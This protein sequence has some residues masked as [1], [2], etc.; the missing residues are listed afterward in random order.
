MLS[1][2]AGRA[3]EPLILTPDQRPRIFLSSTLQELA[4]E[5]A[6]ARAAVDRL[7]LIPVMFE[8]GARP[9]PA[10]AL[11]RAYLAQS[12]VFVG[13]YFE[14][15]GWVAPGEE[16][17]GLEDEYRLSGRLPRL[18]YLKVPAPE[19]EPRLNELL[20]VVRSDDTVSYKSFST[21]EEL[22]RLLA[23]DLAVLMAER[24]LLGGDPSARTSAA[25]AP[26]PAANTARRPIPTPVDSLVGRAAELAELEQ[27]L[28]P[29]N[30]LVTVVGPGGI[31]KTRLALEAARRAA[32]HDL[33]RVAFVPLE[34]VTEPADVLPAI[35]S[36][37]GLGLDGGVAALDTLTGAFGDR[38]FT[39][40]LDNVEQV[41]PAATDVVELL[42]RC[43]AV[44]VLVTSR[45]ALRVRGETLFPLGPLS[46]PD[47][48]TPVEGSAAVRLFVE[49]AA[50]VR[51][52]FSLTDPLDGQAV[53]ELCRRLD[54][55]PLA[56][57]LAAGRSRLLA[58]RALLDRLGSALDLGSGAADL[59]A[60]QRTL[61]DTLAWSEE[62][63]EPRQRAL[64]AALSVFGAPWTVADAEAVA[65]P[66]CPDVLD[67]LA[68]LVENSLVSPATIAPGEPRFRLFDTVRAYASERLDAVRAREPAE[69]AFYRHMIDQIPAYALGVRSLEQARWR[70]ELQLVWRDLSRA[71]AMAVERRDGERTAVAAQLAIAL[72]LL[73]RNNEVEEL[74]ARSL[75]L[76][77]ETSPRQQARLVFYA[78]H[79]AFF[80][81]HY[82]RSS[83]LLTRI[84]PGEVP[85]VRAL[86]VLGEIR[87]MRGFLVAGQGDLDTAQRLLTEGA[88]LLER[89][90]NDGALWFEAFA[91][92]ALG[93]LHLTRG[94]LDEAIAEYETSRQHA[95][96][97]GNVGAHMQALVY[98]AYALL[99]Q[100][101][102]DEARRLLL[103]A[104]PLVEQQPYYEGNAYAL[105]VAAA[106]GL[107]AGSAVE[108]A[109]ALGLAQALRDLIGALVWPLTRSMVDA[110][111]DAVRE[112]LGDEAYEAAFA[113]GLRS[114]PST[115][116]AV[117]SRL[118]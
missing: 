30:R 50:A 26:L 113:E 69:E 101:H 9:H 76:G 94:E 79:T 59:P 88:E 7:R 93:S 108:A 72:W 67:D 89:S 19:R 49:R 66:E 118:P 104:V 68:V 41:L 71:W 111:H 55:I 4:P 117:L 86:D 115:S 92:S 100:G 53:A 84:E 10:R 40:V 102:P 33:D 91:R 44:V 32:A 85:L 2:T 116:A 60:R 46:L 34:A 110:I 3:S 106:Q 83:E 74:M 81:G 43:P 24:F 112:S 99:I 31:G 61:R 35:A 47:D 28:G 14:R 39:L 90:T 82:E 109:R 56:L 6:A 37:I 16:V 52:G 29:G 13:L 20:D 62:L 114:D 65:P 48:D 80:L 36:A 75:E 107:H 51:P 58:P 1:V 57:E 42:S 98:T 70:A 11:Y 105:E 5:R 38:P 63:L 27:L 103:A 8:L 77:A 25:A 12:H 95:V 73:G 96:A 17:S 15:Y 97:T 87:A 18:V 22:E 45:A 78:A 21:P 54:G 23:E 64:L